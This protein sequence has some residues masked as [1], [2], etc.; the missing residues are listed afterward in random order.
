MEVAT[1]IFKALLVSL[2]LAGSAYLVAKVNL[3]GLESASDRV[4]DGVYQRVTAADYG[5]DRRGQKLISVVYL[6]ETSMEAMKGYGW[7]RFPPTY[8]QQWQMFDDIMQ[9]GGAPPTA[10]YADF[11]YTG[12]GGPNEGFDH[13][14]AG[15][16]AATKASVWG[17]QPGCQVDPLIKIACI[18]AAGGTPFIFAKPSPGEL[19]IFTDTQAKIDAVSVLAPALVNVQAYPMITSYGFTPAKNAALGVH[20]FDISPAL[21]M[22]EA[23]CLTRKDACGVPAFVLLRQRAPQ[24]LA[25]KVFPATDV[26]TGFSAPLDVVWGSR[27]DPDY[28]AITK[29]V[30]GQPAPCRAAGA[31]WLERLGEQLTLLRGPATG[32]RQECPY[33]LTLG[34]DR[35]VSGLGLQSSDLQ[36]VL[37]G[38]LIMV[39]GQF[40]TS[41]D[42]VESPVQGQA[43]GVH[44]HAMALDNL[45]EDGL[46][47]RRNANMMLDSDLLKSLL[48]AA[49]AFCGVMGVMA[50]NSLLDHAIATR[51]ESKLRP[52]VYA[53][54]YLGIF[55]TSI[56]IVAMAT[57]LG[58][59][60]LHSAPINWIGIYACVLGF[61]FYAT[62]ETL[63]EDILGSIEHWRWVQRLRARLH[64]FQ[65]FLK[66]EED[67]LIKPKPKPKPAKSEG[68]V[69]AEA[70]AQ[71]ASTE[72]PSTETVSAKTSAEEP[73]E[74]S[75]PSKETPENVQS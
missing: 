72:T 7:N 50:R 1:R 13:F 46:N 67:R 25:G 59:S 44:Y 32:S 34:Y 4:A 52:V 8:D 54:L 41:N 24:A 26:G 16:A 40:R 2:L 33:N 51:T 27:P 5:A 36:R 12:A 55:G 73:P 58:V 71:P 15:I 14:I 61:L 23:W 30:T 66:F 35:M 22:Y 42:W 18:E 57:W 29:A 48:I 70:P 47:Y 45:V 10:V 62:R 20:S 75:G 69:S 6:D 3:F 17:Q 39:G 31:G 19:D 56:G 28:L 65:A 64:L 53:P 68:E 11:V 37:A 60:L 38:K 9:V 63:P 21:G 49:L 74:T 43:P